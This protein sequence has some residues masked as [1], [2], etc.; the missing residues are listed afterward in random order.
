MTRF[1]RFRNEDTTAVRD[2]NR[3][4]DFCAAFFPGFIPGAMRQILTGLRSSGAQPSSRLLRGWG[5]WVRLG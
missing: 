5:G 2:V 3:I 1:G 4:C